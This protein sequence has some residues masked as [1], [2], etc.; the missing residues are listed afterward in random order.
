M[1]GVQ[2][3]G[4]PNIVIFKMSSFLLSRGVGGVG[5]LQHCIIFA[6]RAMM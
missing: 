3:F 1:D 5:Y 2:G 6:C 4:E